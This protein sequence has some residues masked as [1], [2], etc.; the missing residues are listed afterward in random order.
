[1]KSK[2]EVISCKTLLENCHLALCNKK[3]AIPIEIP[4]SFEVCSNFLN[5]SYKNIS[6]DYPL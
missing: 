4:Y 5:I 2:S 1:M 6:S 3:T